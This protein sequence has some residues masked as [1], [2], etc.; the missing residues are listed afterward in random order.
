[1]S[2]TLP[3]VADP[4]APSTNLPAS[5]KIAVRWD[6][7]GTMI[8]ALTVGFTL[9]VAV[10]STVMTRAA[11]NEHG[12]NEHAAVPICTDQIA[13][14]HGM[15]QGEPLHACPTEDSDNCYWDAATRGNGQGLSFVNVNGRVIYQ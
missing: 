7:I 6:A 3:R 8:V 10:T 11:V 2:T 9:G 13:D 4:A 15:C 14:S 5:R 1:V 12:V